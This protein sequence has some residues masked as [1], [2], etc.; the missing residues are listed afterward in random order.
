MVMNNSVW[1]VFKWVMH[2]CVRLHANNQFGV[3]VYTCN[4]QE[5][6]FAVVFTHTQMDIHT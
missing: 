5:Y 6:A 3:H 1:I 4:L 2:V